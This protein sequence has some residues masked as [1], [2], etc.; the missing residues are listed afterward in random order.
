MTTFSVA[1]RDTP[2]RATSDPGRVVVE[3]A[4]GALMLRYGISSYEALTILTG[5][6]RDAE[7]GLQRVARLLMTGICQGEVSDEDALLVRWLE[8]RLR[9]DPEP[10][11][12]AR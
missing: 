12:A 1:V 7:V 9:T 2:R 8:H 11:R 6:A 10:R 3:Q 4:K 5:W